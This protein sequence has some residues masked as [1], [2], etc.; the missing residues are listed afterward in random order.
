MTFG[1]T[2]KYAL[3]FPG[4]DC[5]E[6][7]RGN[8]AFACGAIEAGAGFA[9]WYPGRPSSGVTDVSAMALCLRVG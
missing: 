4:E 1:P 5:V 2:S 8:G 9:C 7:L 6:S 3:L